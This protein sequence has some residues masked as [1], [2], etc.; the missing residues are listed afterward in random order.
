M[1]ATITDTQ[2]VLADMLTENTGSHMLDSGGAYGRHWERNQGQT[3]EGMLDAPS[4]YFQGTSDGECWGFTVDV[5]HFLDARVEYNAEL[6][7][8]FQAFAELPEN[9]SE[10]WLAL[11]EEWAEGRSDEWR[12]FN[13]YNDETLLS[14]TIQGTVFPVADDWFVL[15]QIHGGCD[16]RGGYTAPRVFRIVHDDMGDGFDLYWGW[17]SALVYAGENR[18][19]YD[20]G[21]WIDLA[22][23]V[24]IDGPDTEDFRRR[25]DGVWVY[26]PTGAVAEVE[27]DNDV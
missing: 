1:E 11:M 14:Q 20:M 25:E 6:T 12:T 16:V 21:G 13:S 26:T 18:W 17:N 4:A 23:G 27:A 5:F 8:D 19:Y 2:R 15:L 22:D 9:K 24:P 3:V 7:E 10:G